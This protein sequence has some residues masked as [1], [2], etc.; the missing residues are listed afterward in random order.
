MVSAQRVRRYMKLGLGAIVL[1]AALIWG[2]DW[3][4]LW[5]KAARNGNAF[6]QVEVHYS[7]A[8]RL[9]NK[10]TEQHPE[11]ARME[12]CVHSLFPHYDDSPCWY[13]VRHTDQSEN[14]DGRG[15]HFYS[16]E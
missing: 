2:S 7:Y 10:R 15:W 14:L 11:Q 12:E 16:D 1:T 6:G 4:V 8:V 3:L 9:K 5:I 13:L